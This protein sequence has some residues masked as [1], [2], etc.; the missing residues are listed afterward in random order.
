MILDTNNIISYYRNNIVF[1]E[2]Y[3]GKTQTL[4]DIE[5]EFNK[6]RSSKMEFNSGLSQHPCIIKINRLFEKQFGMDLFCLKVD[7]TKD[8]DSY[9]MPIAMNF[10]IANNVDLST[11]VEGNMSDGFR[12]KENNGLCIIV[13]IS[14]GILDYNRITDSEIVSII[15]HEIGHNFADALYDDIKFANQKMMVEY[16]K[17]LIS[18]ASVAGMANSLSD[19]LKAKEKLKTMNNSYR[20][21]SEKHPKKVSKLRGILDSISGKFKDYRSYK[22]E[23][24]KRKTGGSEFKK[25]KRVQGT[26]AKDVAR[27]SLNRQNEVLADKFAGIYGY[28]TEIISGL[29]KIEY[30]KSKAAKKLE[31]MGGRL[32]EASREYDDAIKDINDYYEHPQ[33]I[34]RINEEI[35]L[36]EREVSK[37][38]IDPRFKLVIYNQINQLR[39]I[40][41]KLTTTSKKL[42][43]DENAKNIYNDYVNKN[44]PDAVNDEI[45]DKIEE[46][47]DKLIEEDKKKN[48][49][50]K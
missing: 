4:L 26:V 19:Y 10:D 1:N 8:F 21:K 12:W 46:A 11:L 48:K 25:Y 23:I 27:N 13:N 18:Y 41:D 42:S 45:E 44:C 28:G 32:A 24:K 47:L 29:K 17:I 43:K 2:A 31:S 49:I 14:Y 40:L 36:L 30:K 33:L 5:S 50:K 34:Q 9:T 3:I 16:E 38:D 15:L 6:L 39:D 20:M 35:K 7:V 22:K 37:E